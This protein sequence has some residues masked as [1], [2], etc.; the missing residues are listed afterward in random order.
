MI[1]GIKTCTGE[2]KGL[3][4]EI[5]HSSQPSITGTSMK[6]VSDEDENCNCNTNNTHFFVEQEMMKEAKHHFMKCRVR[7]DSKNGCKGVSC[8]W[9]LINIT[10]TSEENEGGLDV[11]DCMCRNT[12]L[13]LCQLKPFVRWEDS[14]IDVLTAIGIMAFVSVTSLVVCYIFDR[15]IRREKTHPYVEAR[16]MQTVSPQMTGQQPSTSAERKDNNQGNITSVSENRPADEGAETVECNV[17]LH[18]APKE[19]D[20]DVSLLEEI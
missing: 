13:A 5:H 1:C 8:D 15:C 9:K 2:N 4:E 19:S 17:I 12:C 7:Q 16:E 6:D 14:N 18:N 11:T 10:E 3:S 20:T